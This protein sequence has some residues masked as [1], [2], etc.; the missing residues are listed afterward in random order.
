[1]SGILDSIKSVVSDVAYP[2]RESET[3]RDDHDA[4]VGATASHDAPDGLMDAL[5]GDNGVK[6]IRT[7][8]NI[9]EGSGEGLQK[10]AVAHQEEMAERSRLRNEGLFES[11]V[12]HDKLVNMSDEHRAVADG[13]KM[14][15]NEEE[16][17]SAAAASTDSADGERLV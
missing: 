10:K 16:G 3:G 8:G 2:N 11:H 9:G 7:H 4:A 15:G 14:F 17:S 12:K 1:M 6:T 5:H 13:S